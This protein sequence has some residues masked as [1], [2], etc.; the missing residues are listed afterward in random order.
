M[1]LVLQAQARA[2]QGKTALHL[3]RTGALLGLAVALRLTN[4]LYALALVPA[5]MCDGARLR[6]R[7]LALGIVYRGIRVRRR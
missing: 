3:W 4:A 2:R 6:A 5:L 1:A 7:L